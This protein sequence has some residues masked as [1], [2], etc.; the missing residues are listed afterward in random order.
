GDRVRGPAEPGRLA[1]DRLVGAATPP[2]AGQEG[3]AG[4]D[5][6]GRGRAGMRVHIYLN[7]ERPSPQLLAMKEGM[8]RHGLKPVPMRPLR[9]RPCDLAVCWGV[10]R[11][12][13]FESGQRTLVLERAY[14]GDRFNVW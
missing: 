10:K 7:L 8:E 2:R 12:G 6:G 4:P 3:R 13:A 11:Q 9:P 1:G 5:P 14:V